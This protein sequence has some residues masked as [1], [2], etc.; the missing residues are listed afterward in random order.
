MYSLTMLA[1]YGEIYTYRTLLFH[2]VKPCG[3]LLQLDNNNRSPSNLSFDFPGV[4]SVLLLHF[5]LIQISPFMHGTY[6]MYDDQK[7]CSL[8]AHSY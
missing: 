6:V 3:N 2:W 5:L 1:T 8:L 4:I 7:Q